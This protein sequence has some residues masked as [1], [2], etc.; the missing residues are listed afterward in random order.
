MIGAAEIG[1]LSMVGCTSVHVY[2]KPKIAILSNGDEIIEYNVKEL[3]MGQVRDANRPM[4]IA[5]SKET[6]SEVIDLGI[7]SDIKHDLN[8]CIKNAIH[9]NYDIIISS[10]KFN[11]YKN[12]FEKKY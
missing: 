2:N 4:L 5:L 12:F 6:E 9:S 8:A 1:L 3:K 11:Y 10:G 7:M